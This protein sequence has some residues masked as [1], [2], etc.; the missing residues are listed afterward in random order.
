MA[1][2]VVI[3]DRNVN[4]AGLWRRRA[5]LIPE[6]LRGFSRCP[7]R[8]AS[9]VVDGRAG[10]PC[11]PRRTERKQ[12]DWTFL[13][14]IVALTATVRGLLGRVRGVKSKDAPSERGIEPTPD[15]TPRSA[16]VSL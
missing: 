16:E 8:L 4:A 6:G 5:W 7:P 2:P 9:R 3:K 10:R 1:K 14:V 15:A 12:S 13:L 11:S